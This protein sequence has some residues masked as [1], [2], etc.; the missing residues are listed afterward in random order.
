MRVQT[1]RALLSLYKEILTHEYNAKL[2][3]SVRKAILLI[4]KNDDNDTHVVDMMREQCAKIRS[5]SLRDRLALFSQLM[6]D[7]SSDSSSSESS[8]SDSDS[9]SSSV[10]S[11]SHIVG[12]RL[13]DGDNERHY[14]V[15]WSGYD[16]DDDTWEPMEKLIEDGCGDLIA[17]FHDKTRDFV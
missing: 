15:R 11:V 8:S 4:K 7:S 14:L 17:E 2:R 6:V 13:K 9:S 3:M 5:S 16:S 1:R 12:M 10:F